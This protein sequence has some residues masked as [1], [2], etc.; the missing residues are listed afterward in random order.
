MQESQKNVSIH[1][2]KNSSIVAKPVLNHTNSTTSSP[3]Q[4]LLDKLASI[5]A[6]TQELKSST[7][8]Q[9]K[10]IQDMKEKLGKNVTSKC[11]LK[12]E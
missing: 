3:N 8:E 7:I 4:S 1:H 9:N 12:P 2:T 11:E 10:K 5:K 6:H